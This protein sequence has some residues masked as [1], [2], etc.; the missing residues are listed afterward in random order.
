MPV[1][2]TNE[3]IVDPKESFKAQSRDNLNQSFDQVKD[4]IGEQAADSSTESEKSDKK[5]PAT[6]LLSPPDITLSPNDSNDID[7]SDSISVKGE[8]R[9]M[10]LS[11]LFFTN[12]TFGKR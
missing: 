4:V 9:E 7:V 8:S 1:T 5:S 12:T 3:Q 10:G 6:E 2:V 11:S